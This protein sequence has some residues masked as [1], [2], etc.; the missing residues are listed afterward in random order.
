[1]GSLSSAS[2]L[3]DSKF[4][5]TQLSLATAVHDAEDWVNNRPP[6]AVPVVIEK[7]DGVQLSEAIQPYI[8]VQPAVGFQP[9]GGAHRGLLVIPISLLE[10]I[11]TFC[12]KSVPLLGS[13]VV[14]DH[15]HAVCQR[16]HSAADA[17]RVWETAFR[18]HWGEAAIPFAA[19]NAT[20]W[21]DRYAFIHRMLVQEFRGNPRCRRKMRLRWT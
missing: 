4:S 14:I 21:K 5:S 20:H 8:G 15:E 11:F 16:F 10:R 9:P 6:G 18:H 1:M 3:G 13:M 7:L 19:P 17:H 12:I 2:F